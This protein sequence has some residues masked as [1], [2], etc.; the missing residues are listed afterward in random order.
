MSRERV[1]GKGRPGGKKC[2]C[3][4]LEAGEHRAQVWPGRGPVQGLPGQEGKFIKSQGS[5]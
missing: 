4:G 2:T 5:S 1:P 3:K